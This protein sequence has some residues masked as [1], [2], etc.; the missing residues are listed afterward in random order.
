MKTIDIIHST[1]RNAA[2]YIEEFES[3]GEKVIKKIKSNPLFREILLSPVGYM[4]EAIEEYVRA[5][6]S[7]MAAATETLSIFKDEDVKDA[8]VDCMVS[9][10][11]YKE[12]AEKVIADLKAL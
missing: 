11:G 1:Q 7:Q 2:I 8:A 4:V 12:R 6:D 5:I 9:L 10:Y 3:G